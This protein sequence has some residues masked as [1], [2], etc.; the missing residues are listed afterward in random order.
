MH[1]D[2]DSSLGGLALLLNAVLGLGADDATTPVASGILVLVGV[3]LL[4]GSEELGELGLIFGADLSDSQDSSGL[5]N[6]S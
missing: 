4:D 1:L 6:R 5:L 3:A 2:L